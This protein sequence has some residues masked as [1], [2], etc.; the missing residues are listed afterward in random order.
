MGERGCEA[1]GITAIACCPAL[2]VHCKHKI[3]TT[4]LSA[5]RFE[6]ALRT[7]DGYVPPP[8]CAGKHLIFDREQEAAAQSS[9]MTSLMNANAILMNERDKALSRAEMPGLVFPSLEVMRSGIKNFL[10]ERERQAPEVRQGVP[11]WNGE[12]RLS[13]AG[14]A[15][16]DVG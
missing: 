4:R 8:Q 14:W 2:I 11:Y 6:G 7:S 12:S 16:W 3:L 1:A 5:C 15:P 9:D 13:K 10:L